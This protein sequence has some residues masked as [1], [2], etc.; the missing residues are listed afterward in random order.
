[1]PVTLDL[2]GEDRCIEKVSS[3]KTSMLELYYDNT[4]ALPKC[5]IEALTNIAPKNPVHETVHMMLKNNAFFLTSFE[6]MV[7]LS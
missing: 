4:S 2:S 7:S 6:S 1:M 5:N 3:Q